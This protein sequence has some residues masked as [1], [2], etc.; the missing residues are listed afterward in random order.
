VG[1]LIDMRMEEVRRQVRRGEY[2]VDADAV[3][4]AIVQRMALRRAL[5]PFVL[6]DTGTRAR[7]RAFVRCAVA[8]EPVLVAA[9]EPALGA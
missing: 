9:Q 2:V 3:A 1:Q 4:A 5:D 8:S 7:P 6:D